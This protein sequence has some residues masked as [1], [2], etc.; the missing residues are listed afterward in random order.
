MVSADGGR[1]GPACGKRMRGVN[2]ANSAGLAPEIIRNPADNTGRRAGI[3]NRH[4]AMGV[5][6]A[7]SMRWQNE[8]VVANPLSQRIDHGS[9]T[10]YDIPAGGKRAVNH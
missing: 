7:V 9:R 8:S 10:V 3:I 4:V 5:G 1:I 2:T 6:V